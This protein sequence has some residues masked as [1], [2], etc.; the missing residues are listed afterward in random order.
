MLNGAN[1]I[2]KVF[3]LLTHSML[4][5]LVAL[6]SP[7]RA[8]MTIEQAIQLIKESAAEVSQLAKEFTNSTNTYSSKIGEIWGSLVQGDSPDPDLNG[9][10]EY[11]ERSGFTSCSATHKKL[12]QLQHDKGLMVTWSEEDWRWENLLQIT[13]GQ[14]Q[15]HPFATLLINRGQLDKL[16]NTFKIAYGDGSSLL[17]FTSSTWTDVRVYWDEVIKVLEEMKTTSI[18][19]WFCEPFLHFTHF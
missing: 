15:L 6:F 17:S 3:Q 14:P 2:Q 10:L 19:Q 9:Q 11:A 16:N 7:A 5:L 18:S 4:N 12:Y 13:K 8:N 1:K